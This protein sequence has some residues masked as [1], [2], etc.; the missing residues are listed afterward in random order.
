VL[1]AVADL[2]RHRNTLS[3]QAMAVAPG[4]TAAPGCNSIAPSCRFM[5]AIDEPGAYALFT[6]H[7][8]EEFQARLLASTGTEVCRRPLT[9]EYKAPTTSTTRR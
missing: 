2:L 5:V 9:H 4:Q 6:E 3:S 7:R 8:P 1:D